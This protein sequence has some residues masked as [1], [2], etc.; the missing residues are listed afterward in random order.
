VAT[1][2]TV[3][4]FDGGEIDFAQ[5]PALPDEVEAHWYSSGDVLAVVFVGLSADVDAC[6]GNSINTATGFEFVSNAPLPN[7]ACDDFPTLIENSADQG[8]QI[9]DDRV[10]YLSLIP[11]GVPGTLF[12]S[13]EK[14]DPDVTGVGITGSVDMPDPSVLPEISHDQLAC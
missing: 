3:Y 9:C 4:S 5:L 10:G 1:L 6:P 2:N 13:I 8:V 7:G 14:P 11:T 12:A